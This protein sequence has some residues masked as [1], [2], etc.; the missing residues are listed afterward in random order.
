MKRNIVITAVT[1]AALIGGGTAT[2][3]AV[4]GDDDGRDTARVGSADVTLSDAIDT[5]LR[6]TPGKAVSAELDDADDDGEK[7]VWEVDILAGDDTRHS[8]RVDPAT[9]KVL[10]SHTDTEDDD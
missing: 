9:G 1:A 4:T 3:L 10:D 5:A 2:A 8:V 7:A 6:D